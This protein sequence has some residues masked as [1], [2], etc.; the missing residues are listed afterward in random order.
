M[1]YCYLYTVS[2][3]QAVREAIITVN[4]W[5]E[6]GLQLGLP[7]N[8]VD[9][10]RDDHT[11]VE[12]CKKRLISRWIQT[13][14][15]SWAVLVKALRHPFMHMDTLADEI[16]KKYPCKCAKVIKLS[17]VVSS[18]KFCCSS[19]CVFTSLAPIH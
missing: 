4:D 10:L 2:D 6:L 3:L 12:E 5:H 11:T 14:H 7:L 15:A 18:L 19:S 9:Q 8:V 1:I 17:C 13:G 16:A